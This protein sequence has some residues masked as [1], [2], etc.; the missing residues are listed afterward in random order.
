MMLVYLVFILHIVLLLFVFINNQTLE[1]KYYRFKSHIYYVGPLVICDDII[2][3]VLP[4]FI[5]YYH[6]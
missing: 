6:I 4:P 1:I 3:Y 5:N 2:S